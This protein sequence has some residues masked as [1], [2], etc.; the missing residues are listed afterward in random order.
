MSRH[1]RHRRESSSPD[2]RGFQASKL[3]TPQFEF[4]KRTVDQKKRTQEARA[5]VESTHTAMLIAEL[6]IKQMA[7]EAVEYSE[8]MQSI[9]R[10]E[11]GFIIGHTLVSTVMYLNLVSIFMTHNQV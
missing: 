1:A 6:V 3:Y 5:L 4:A 11:P 8:F 9:K 7:S 2:V 10:Q